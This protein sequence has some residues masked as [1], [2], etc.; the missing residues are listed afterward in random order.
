M[1]K[2][3][4]FY[5]LVFGI[6][7]TF[8][9]F[10]FTWSWWWSE[11]LFWWCYIGEF[12]RLCWR[13]RTR[14][15]TVW[16]ILGVLVFWLNWHPLHRICFNWNQAEHKDKGEYKTDLHF[17]V[18]GNTIGQGQFIIQNRCSLKWVQWVQLHPSIF[19]EDLSCNH[20]FENFS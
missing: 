5:K 3:R 1:H 9:I 6:I 7:L 10:G 13:W 8:L 17:S 16:F 19:E 20:Q 15:S 4:F 14:V 18:L 12:A 2:L 11:M